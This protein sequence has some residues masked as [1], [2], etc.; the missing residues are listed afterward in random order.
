M[1]GHWDAGAGKWRPSLRNAC[2][3]C[4]G[5][6]SSEAIAERCVL[7]DGPG[8]VGATCGLHRTCQGCGVEV[9]Q[10]EASGA[11]VGEPATP[12]TPSA[13]LPR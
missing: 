1:T 11:F 4:G 9:L 12:P 6:L 5:L 8:G 2:P 3:R 7:G 10:Y 13:T